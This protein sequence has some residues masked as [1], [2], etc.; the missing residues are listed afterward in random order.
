MSPFPHLPISRPDW[1]ENL[2]N[3]K[4]V[5]ETQLSI[6]RPDWFENLKN[7]KYVAETQLSIFRNP[8]D[9][10]IW[11]YVAETQFY[12]QYPIDLRIWNFEILSHPFSIPQF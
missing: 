12:F 9:L 2:K 3:L 6:S 5:A 4:Y 1:F 10:W 11:K 8:I 7:L